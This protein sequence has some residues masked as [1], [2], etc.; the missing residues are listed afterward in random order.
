VDTTIIA[1]II[2]AA[3]TVLASVITIVASRKQALPPGDAVPSSRET[4]SAQ[5]VE[6]P[7]VLVSPSQAM[8]AASPSSTGGDLTFDEVVQFIRLRYPDA[9]MGKTAEQGQYFERAKRLT[10]YRLHSEDPLYYAAVQANG[11]TMWLYLH[12]SGK[13]CCGDKV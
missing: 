7:E 11:K 1:A 5:R 13:I 4:A 2:G 3:G 8:N 9:V 12:K 10:N 6:T